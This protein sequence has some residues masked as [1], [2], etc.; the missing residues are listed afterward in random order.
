VSEKTR[1]YIYRIAVA[2]VPLLVGYGVVEDSQAALW[3][4]L[5]GAALGFGT[6][7]L[8]SA[9]TSTKSDRP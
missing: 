9:N 5:A 6:N 3:L 4:G 2:A 1:A 8:A 7:V